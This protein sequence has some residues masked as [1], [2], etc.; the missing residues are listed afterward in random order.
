MTARMQMPQ[1]SVSG[2]SAVTTT[3]DAQERASGAAAR[4]VGPSYEGMAKRGSYPDSDVVYTAGFRLK[5]SDDAPAMIILATPHH[6]GP[7]KEVAIH[8]R[9]VRLEACE[10]HD[11]VM[12]SVETCGDTEDKQIWT[13][14]LVDIA[15]D[16]VF[17]T[18][19]RSSYSD[20]DCWSP[21]GA[22]FHMAVDFYQHT[23]MTRRGVPVGAPSADFW[24]HGWLLG[25]RFL[26]GHASEAGQELLATAEIDGT[27]RTLTTSR[28]SPGAALARS[29]DYG[30]HAYVDVDGVQVLM[31]AA[32]T[33]PQWHGP[34][35]PQL[36]RVS[37]RER[38]A[39]W[40]RAKEAQRLGVILSTGEAWVIAPSDSTVQRL[41][42]LELKPDETVL[43]MVWMDSMPAWAVRL[44]RPA[45]M[46][47]YERVVVAIVDGGA[48]TPIVSVDQYTDLTL[49]ALD[50]SPDGTLSQL[51]GGTHL[52]L[53][54]QIGD[55]HNARRIGRPRR[56]KDM[57]PA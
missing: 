30:A 39:S 57:S 41:T 7:T 33:N 53:S 12:M 36:A 26:L 11:T 49:N 50:L 22:Y 43:A 47:Q 17:H 56:L 16:E 19:V 4:V 14:R 52:P 31:C 13:H 18:S 3:L 5:P 32:G 10:N 29:G 27:K 6:G 55:E 8:G 25:D 45:N 40:D 21:S 38:F 20:Q 15:T 44:T 9:L 46:G 48:L 2:P 34:F 37:A 24:W 1:L 42:A 51:G 23:F 28:M 35:L 54:W